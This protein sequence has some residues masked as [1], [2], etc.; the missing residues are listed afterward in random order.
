MSVALSFGQRGVRG[1]AVET[2]QR[3]E[4]NS[5][6][7]EIQR[8]EEIKPLSKLFADVDE[9]PYREPY[10]FRTLIPSQDPPPIKPIR[11]KTVLLLSNFST[12]LLLAAFFQDDLM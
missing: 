12:V 10:W 6:R 9:V 5:A 8:R 7:C 2:V 4:L 1:T 11:S 3:E